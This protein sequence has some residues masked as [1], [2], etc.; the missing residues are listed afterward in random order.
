MRVV[1]GRARR[2]HVSLLCAASE[3]RLLL[4]P[5]PEPSAWHVGAVV[6]AEML[7]SQAPSEFSVS[8]G[9]RPGPCQQNTAC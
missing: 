3:A 4:S 5:S 6:Q 1:R 2:R 8:P 7:P 9:G